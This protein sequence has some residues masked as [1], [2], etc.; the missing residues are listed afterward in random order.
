[1]INILC[2]ISAHL[3]SLWTTIG[4]NIGSIILLGILTMDMRK[5][6]RKLDN[7]SGHMNEGSN[8]FRYAI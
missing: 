8:T 6:N 2:G 7:G 3:F 4:L 1:M 5:Q